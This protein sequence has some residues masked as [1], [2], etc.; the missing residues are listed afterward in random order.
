MTAAN[1]VAS[2]PVETRRWRGPRVVEVVGPAGA[3]KT[4][5]AHALAARDPRVVPGLAVWARPRRD[6]L[7]SGA[8]LAPNLVA[9]VFA[10]RPPGARAVAQ[11]IRLGA[12]RRAVD[13]L[14]VDGA[15]VYLLDEGPLFALAWLEVHGGR[16]DPWYQRWRRRVLEEWKARLV[17]VIRLDASDEELARRIRLRAQPHR[18]KQAADADIKA[19]VARYRSAFDRTLAEIG[20]TGQVTILELRTDAER[21]ADAIM[22]AHHTLEAVRNGR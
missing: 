9:A 10:Q 16:R 2:R 6:L 19:F 20:D 7:R 17:A 8:E 11:M 4:T 1:V 12:L 3:G 13:R 15:D 14:P 21:A 22:R 5:L 18:I